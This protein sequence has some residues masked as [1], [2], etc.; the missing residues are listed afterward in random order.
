[1][2][3]TGSLC[4]YGT[5]E[6]AYFQEDG[7][8]IAVSRV[9]S[10]VRRILKESNLSHEQ[11][12]NTIAGITGI[13]WPEDSDMF[14]TAL[15]EKIKLKSIDV[16][17]DCVIA[18]FSG[19]QKSYG[20]SICAGSGVNAVIIRPDGVQFVMGEY[21]GGEVQ[22]GSMLAY[23]AMRRIV[24]SDLGIYPPTKL[25]ELFLSHTGVSEPIG[26]MKELMKNE[27]GLLK[28]IQELVPD[29]IA[30]A[31]SG[32]QVTN[33]LIC[34][35][36]KETCVYFIAGLKK[37]DMLSVECDIV[38]A[39]GVY[40]GPNNSLTAKMKKILSETLPNADLIDA[41]YE[42]VVGACLLG[43]LQMEAFTEDMTGKLDVSAQKY[44]LLREF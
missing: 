34:E 14:I 18:M 41:K 9:D 12:T 11:I 31:G 1:M 7:I 38:L 44:G 15:Q 22:G 25:T 4:A 43:F 10:V 40:K 19:T 39:G 28:D 35:Y 24:D 21:F 16:L 17:N 6:G 23:R 33:D 5:T 29:I 8:D 27:T 20:A 32:D 36:A 13:D 37:M 26:L 42:P 3:D 2:D 30:L